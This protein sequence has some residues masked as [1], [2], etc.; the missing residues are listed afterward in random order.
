MAGANPILI[1]SSPTSPAS[2]RRAPVPSSPQLPSPSSFIRPLS[3]GFPAEEDQRGLRAPDFQSAASL[4]P[5]AREDATGG[6]DGGL[7]ARET[8]ETAGKLKKPRRRMKKSES[9]ILNSD[10]PEESIYFARKSPRAEPPKRPPVPSADHHEGEMA[11]AQASRRRRSWTPVMDTAIHVPSPAP[12][13]PLGELLSNFS[14]TNPNPGGTLLSGERITNGEATTKR[15]KIELAD[16][17]TSAPVTRQPAKKASKAKSAKK[18]VTEKASESTE[19]PPA[20]PAKRQKGPKKPQTITALATKAYQPLVEPEAEQ[21]TVS[22]FFTPRKQDLPATHNAEETATEA[23]KVKK[24][25]KPRQPKEGSNAAKEPSK[26][27]ATTKPKKAK[28]KVKFNE[29][30]F[31]HPLYSPE[32]AALQMQQQDFLFG[33][34]SQLATDEDPKFIRELQTAMAASEMIGPS[35]QASAQRES[36]YAKVPSAP[37]GTSLSVGQADR[38]LWCSA[39][40]DFK[41]GL[42]RERSGLN[43]SG[44]APTA[45][46]ALKESS[47]SAEA[48]PSCVKSPTGPKRPPVSSNTSHKQGQAAAGAT[49]ASTPP[50]PDGFIDIDEIYD[51]DPSP[52]TPSPP[53]RRPSSAASPVQ[54]LTFS[55]TSAATAPSAQNKHPAALSTTAYLKST[56]PQ[57]STIQPLLFPRITHAIRTQPPSTNPSQ[58][59]WNQKILL[60]DPIVL[61]D[62]TAWLNDTIGIR[63]P[64]QRKVAKKHQPRTKSAEKDDEVDQEVEVKDEEVKCWMVQ[65]WCEERSVCCLWKEGLRGGV[66]SR[67]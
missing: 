13:V 9:I 59:S 37:H 34:S 65:K 61:E 54:P 39:A 28:A 15:R 26:Q 53:R 1:Q 46:A 23:A 2:R 49:T 14:Y 44:P 27:K 7:A 42:H 56:D 30:D 64:V 66:R 5:L 32:K 55:T 22:A 16:S 8:T 57:W 47:E 41:G 48:G 43:K 25:R 29:V 21:S 31:L 62:L 19:M 38:E 40:R 45:Q 12:R 3:S 18:D 36:S 17:S 63:I 6:D 52:P 67:Y 24:P 4:L 35:T 33:T 51:D 20:Q 50:E 10:E 60:Y 11:A 58:P